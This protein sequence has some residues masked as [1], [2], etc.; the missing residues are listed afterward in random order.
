M[1][2]ALFN[3]PGAHCLCAIATLAFSLAIEI[4]IYSLNRLNRSKSLKLS[5]R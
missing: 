2:Q 3:A 1:G 4:D 5:G